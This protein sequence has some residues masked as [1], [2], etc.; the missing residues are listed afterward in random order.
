LIDAIV[1]LMKGF[2]MKILD[3]FPTSG[4]VLQ[5]PNWAPY[6]RSANCFVDMPLLMSLVAFFIAYEAVILIVRVVIWV[7]NIIFP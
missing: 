3:L 4:E 6:L 1:N 2:I 5:V 7:R